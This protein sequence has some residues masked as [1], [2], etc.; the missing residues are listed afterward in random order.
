MT[1]IKHD[2]P[3]P[4]WPDATPS[5]LGFMF[6]ILR[7]HIGA[8]SIIFIAQTMAALPLVADAVT[9]GR[10]PVPHLDALARVAAYRDDDARQAYFDRIN[11]P[12]SQIPKTYFVSDYANLGRM[13]EAFAIASDVRS[14]E[15]NSLFA[16]WRQNMATFRSDPRFVEIIQS[17]GYIGYWDEYGWP[18]DCARTT[19]TIVCQ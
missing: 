17:A 18:P 11:D 8:V 1:A 15:A 6:P 10:M 9:G 16:F 5:M 14:F 4:N 13:D 7:P 12:T 19:D 3:I 2:Q